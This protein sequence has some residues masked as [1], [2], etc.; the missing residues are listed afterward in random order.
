MGYFLYL[1]QVIKNKPLNA[2]TQAAVYTTKME[3]QNAKSLSERAMY[4]G[5][6]FGGVMILTNIAYII[7]LRV[8]AFST[9]FLLLTAA[10]PF[11]AGRLAATYRK[12]ERN[13]SINFV[14]AWLFLVIMYICAAILTA[15]AQYIYFA[16]IDNGFFME[17][18]QEQFSLVLETEG[19]DDAVKDEIRT[20]ANLLAAMSTRD[21]ILQIFSTNI[22]ISPIITF[23][24]AI[25]VRKK[26]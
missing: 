24:I 13:N 21:I 9:I 4:Y 7:G 3:Q 1:R 8:E 26:Q 22:I 25:F 12:R 15:I 2:V 6:I 11:I 18:I 14:Q 10:S 20:T 19:L 23:I 5:T 16:L 17:F